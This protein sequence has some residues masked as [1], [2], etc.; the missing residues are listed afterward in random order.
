MNSLE[1]IDSLVGVEGNKLIRVRDAV[2]CC[3]QHHAQSYSLIGSMGQEIL[4]TLL[5][6]SIFQG[7]VYALVGPQ[8]IS[9]WGQAA[10]A[11]GRYLNAG[12]G[13]QTVILPFTPY[14]PPDWLH[15]LA[16]QIYGWAANIKSLSEPYSE[17]ETLPQPQALPVGAQVET[18]KKVQRCLEAKALSQSSP[19]KWATIQR[20]GQ[21]VRYS[22]LRDQD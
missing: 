21:T 9:A 7:D 6:S 4:D 10:V 11:A 8:Q 12:L 15:P 14:D 5:S 17:P 2:R 19:R 13:R 1:F 3:A 18:A 20:G 22:Y 16:G